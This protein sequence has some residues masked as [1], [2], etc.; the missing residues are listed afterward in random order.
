MLTAVQRR[1][2]LDRALADKGEDGVLRRRMG[3][4]NTFVEVPCRVLIRGYKPEQLIGGLTQQDAQAVI[5]PSPILASTF[6]GA[7]GGTRWPKVND[8]LLV[9]G[10]LRNVQATATVFIGPEPVRIEMTV[11]G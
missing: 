5:S 9:Q 2:R 11:R 6:P 10:R 3:T 4:G 8:L 1:E 7:A